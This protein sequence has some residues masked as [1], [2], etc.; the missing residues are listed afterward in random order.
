MT[1]PNTL[2]RWRPHPFVY[3]HCSLAIVLIGMI[4]TVG[5]VLLTA[6]Y[7]KPENTVKIATLALGLFVVVLWLSLRHPNCQVSAG[8]YY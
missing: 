6:R 1:N 2:E 8:C 5:L 4:W 3:F 7:W